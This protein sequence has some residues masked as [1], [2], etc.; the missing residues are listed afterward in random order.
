MSDFLKSWFSGFE[1]GL[2]GL[3]DQECIDILCQCGKA[4][5]ESYS[6]GIYQKIW[7]KANNIPDFF[8]LLN[9]GFD[10]ISVNEVKKNKTYEICYSKCLCDLHTKG[11]INSGKLCECSRQSILY[12]L[13][14]VIADK[15]VEVELIDSILRNADKCIL[16]VTIS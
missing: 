6:L 11:Y 13:N 16:R 15:E 1:K 14:T 12:N 3:P 7:N 2:E 5:S 4:C 10:D 8:A 9:S